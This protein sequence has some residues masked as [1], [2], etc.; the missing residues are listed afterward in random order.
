MA[1]FDLNFLFTSGDDNPRHHIENMGMFYLFQLP[2][3][4]IGLY[5][6]I[7][8][9]NRG[10]S[11]IF[12]WLL[13]APVASSFATP[14]PHAIRSLPMLPAIELICAAGA[15]YL[16]NYK[17]KIIAVI[18]TLWVSVSFLIY[19]HNYYVHYPIDKADV[20]QYGFK[21]AAIESSQLKNSFDQIKISRSIEQAYI[22]WLFYT[23][24]DPKLYQL[25]GSNK[26]FDKYYFDL[27]K[28]DSNNELFVSF[29]DSPNYPKN[30][31]IIRMISLPSGKQIISLSTQQ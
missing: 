3:V 11:V 16:F 12:S 29:I 9:R 7:A 14:S 20:W 28:P 19:L 2:L 27:E 26:H 18:L 25:Y 8:K 21:E 17:N 1:N 24:Y 23:K 6:L 10:A 15:A 4:L 31:K 22:Y 13:L 30:S 5:L